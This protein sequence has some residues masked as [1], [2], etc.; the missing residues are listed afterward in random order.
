MIFFDY[1]LSRLRLKDSGGVVDPALTEQITNDILTLYSTKR[2]KVAQKNSIED[3]DGYLQLVG[4]ENS[5]GPN[6]IYS[7]DASGN[8]GWHSTLLTTGLFAQTQDGAVVSN[9]NVENNLLG[10][11]V[12]SL[13]VPANGFKVGD[14]FEAVLSGVIS[15]QNNHYL[16]IK[17]KSGSQVLATTAG[18]LMSHSTNQ[19]FQIR[20]SFTIRSLGTN[21]EISTFGSFQY[22]N[23]QIQLIGF[24]FTDVESFNTTIQNSLEVTAKWGQIDSDDSIQA[25]S[26]TLHKTY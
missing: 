25:K 19:P 22:N 11:G 5:P 21:G 15:T 24:M 10:S 12:G 7:T 14:S 23:N 6:K 13:S 3:D 20:I 16:T 18:I 9:T 2:D 8:K 1:L 26:F 4:D 17:V